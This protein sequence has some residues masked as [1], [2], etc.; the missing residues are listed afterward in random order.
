M[1]QATAPIEPPRRQP[2]PVELEVAYPERLS[3]WRIF[4]KWLFVVPQLVVVWILGLVLWII[5][6]LAWFGVLFTGRYPRSFFDFA[7]G[8]LRWQANVFAYAMF[9]RDEYP[10]FTLD[11]GSYALDLYIPMAERQSR[12]RLF[13]RWAAAIPNQIVLQLVFLGVL[14]TTFMAWWSILFTGR[15]PRGLFRFAE[16]TMRWWARLQ[17]YTYLLRDEFPPYSVNRDARPGPEVVSLVLGIP[18]M[19]L[20]VAISLLPF[21]GMLGSGE[22]RVTPGP[23]VLDAPE[24]LVAERPSG[25]VNSIRITMIGYVDDAIAPATQPRPGYRFVAF[26]VIAEKDGFWPAWYTVSF[27][28]LDDCL[29]RYDVDLWATSDGF[30]ESRMFFRS[31]STSDR[32]YFQIPEDSTPC[33]LRYQAGLG[34]IVFEFY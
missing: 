24:R 8:V 12:F 14:F 19:A 23:G 9:L 10:P 21:A 26:D 20:Y 1:M 11:A 17:A 6:V 27:F 3:R 13:I 32:V 22:S 25:H 28:S 30:P 29:R 5:T 18:F 16:G 2:H 4:F 34:S 7:S 33:E 31:G 15:Y